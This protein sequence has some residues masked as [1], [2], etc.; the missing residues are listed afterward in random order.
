MDWLL[1]L[2]VI[3]LSIDIV[4]IASAWYVASVIRPLAPD[5]WKKHII[6]YQH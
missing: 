6:D 1:K 4:M 2:I 3:W 5:W